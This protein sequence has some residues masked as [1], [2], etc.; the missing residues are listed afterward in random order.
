M[1]DDEH[2]FNLVNTTIRFIGS[3]LGVLA[4]LIMVA[5]DGTRNALYRVLIGVSMGVVFAPTVPN[6]PLMGFLAG[7]GTDLILARG[8]AAGFSSWFVLEAAARFLSSTDWIV[9]V[10][11]AVVNKG[12]DKR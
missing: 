12:G 9:K 6:L 3:L 1:I 11:Q 10:L 8:T 7:S 2:G 5:P 4:S